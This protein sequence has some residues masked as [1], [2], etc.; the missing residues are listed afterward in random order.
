MGWF[1]SYDSVQTLL[2]SRREWVG[3]GEGQ[4]WFIF[5][6]HV[7]SGVPDRDRASGR[8]PGVTLI[9]S[10]VAGVRSART[11][12]AEKRPITESQTWS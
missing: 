11:S 8:N 3:E 10:A 9:A 6:D 4:R 5:V 2:V 12:A 1:D 7:F